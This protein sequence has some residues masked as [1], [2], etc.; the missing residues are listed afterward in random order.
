MKGGEK[1]KNL[2]I[3]VTA[4]AMVVS[5][6]PKA[7][8]GDTAALGL[9]VTFAQE[10]PVISIELEPGIWELTDVKLGDKI[11]NLGPDGMPIH[12]I[13]NAGNVPVRVEIG[14]FTDLVIPE[15]PQPGLEP[16]FNVFTTEIGNYIWNFSLEWKVLPPDGTKIYCGTI[17]PTNAIPPDGPGIGLGSLSLPLGYGAPIGVMQGITGMSVQYELRAYSVPIPLPQIDQ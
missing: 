4:L 9:Q 15:A 6:L 16:G 2:F 1:M 11:T 10:P 8:A 5:F 17:Y 12:K 7:E 13:I 14:Y 3:I